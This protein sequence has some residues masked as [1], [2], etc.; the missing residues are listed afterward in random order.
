MG[1]NSGYSALSL[2]NLTFVEETVER[3]APPAPSQP[4]PSSCDCGH[5]MYVPSNMPKYV[6]YKCRNKIPVEDLDAVFHEQLRDFFFSPEEVAEHL[7]QADQNLQDKEELVAVL[8]D[9]LQSIQKD[10]DKLCELYMAGEIPKEG[11]GRK[12][13][14][15]EERYQ[16]LEEEIPQLQA[17]IDFLK[18]QYLSRDEIIHEAQDLYT[19]WPQFS[20]DDK[21]RIIET[22]TESI[23]VGDGEIA[24]NL[25]Y[26]PPTNHLLGTHDKKATHPQGFTAA[27]T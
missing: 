1:I 9:E 24:I 10:T 6:C 14:P 7:Q 12:Y 23:V 26:F 4:N 2:T 16:Q 21:R 15:L 8:E 20:F 3:A 5:K 25:N 22:I 18:I 13:R 19:R 17:E 27:T 11:F